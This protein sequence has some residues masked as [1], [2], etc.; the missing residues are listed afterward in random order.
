ML[1]LLMVCIY[2]IW[3]LF[4]RCRVLH[5]N[6]MYPVN[7]PAVQHKAAD[8]QEEIIIIHDDI[9]QLQTWEA[10]LEFNSQATLWNAFGTLWM[11]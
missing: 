3:T 7:Q 1:G 11:H 10:C 9:V 2:L 6:H 8:K 4:S 5:I